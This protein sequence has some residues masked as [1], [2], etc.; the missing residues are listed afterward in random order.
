LSKS[1]ILH[2]WA[3]TRCTLAQHSGLLRQWYSLLTTKRLYMH[4]LQYS[5]ALEWFPQTSRLLRCASSASLF[6][7]RPK[8]DVGHQL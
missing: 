2:S 8:L 4:Q 3:Q 5:A 7:L 6:R 1:A